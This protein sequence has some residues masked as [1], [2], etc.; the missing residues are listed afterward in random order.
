MGFWVK[1]MNNKIIDNP[2]LSHNN[3]KEL[4]AIP[5]IIKWGDLQLSLQL[6]FWVAMNICNSLQLNVLLQ[7]WMLFDKLYEL[8]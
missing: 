4:L 6:G 1:A 2:N 3:T 8:A 7:V 5:I